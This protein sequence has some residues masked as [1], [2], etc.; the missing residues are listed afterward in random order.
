VTIESRAEQA[1]ADQLRRMRGDAVFS[2]G[3]RFYLTDWRNNL[4]PGVTPLDFE[5][6]LKTAAGNELKEIGKGPAKFCAARSSSA[7][8]VNTF[9][10]FRHSPERLVLAGHDGFQ[11]TW[12]E[13]QCPNGL[14]TRVPP[15]LDF[16]AEGL[17]AVVAV[18]SKFLEPFGDAK[19]AAFTDQYGRPFEGASGTPTVAEHPWAEMF[20]LLR[21]KPSQYKHLDAAQLVKHYLGLKHSYPNKI[22]VL[23]YLYWEPINANVLEDC[24]AHRLEVKDFADRVAGCATCFLAI[25]HPDLWRVW[26][27]ASHW[28][29]ISL[30]L[31]RLRERYSFTI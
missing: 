6:D 28:P 20:K 11:H 4:I 24:K 7:L 27:T 19:T 1:A 30:H 14:R 29:G 16:L 9:A 13:K 22:R 25:S 10:P 17:D 26:D 2:A 23:V 12:F 18:E 21:E 3:R 5:Q 15:H 31:A 8:A